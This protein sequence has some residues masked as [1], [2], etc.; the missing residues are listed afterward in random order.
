MS[1]TNLLDKIKGKIDIDKSTFL[2]LFIIIG[3][4]V[5]SFALGRLSIN[6]DY[7]QKIELS[8]SAINQNIIT[9]DKKGESVRITTKDDE[10]KERRYVA[11]KN[12]KMYYPLGCASAKRIKP[13]NEVWF[14][15]ETEA[16]KSGY[17]KSSMCK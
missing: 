4:G 14:S 9:T 1:I 16:I 7:D 13:E 5:S 8:A 10:I 12:G 6:N 17:T 11:S 3:V 2:F 15:T